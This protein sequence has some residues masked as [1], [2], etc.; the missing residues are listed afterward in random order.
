MYNQVRGCVKINAS[1]R[2]LYKF[3]NKIHCGHIY[4]FRQYVRKD[5]FYAEIYRHDLKKVT[6]FAGECGIELKHYE[7]E[8]ISKKLIRYRKRIGI[9]I[10]TAAVIAASVYFSNVVVTIDIQG[11]STVSDRDILAALDELDIRQGSFIGGIDFAY[12]EKELRLMIDDISWAAIRHTGNRIVVEVT[13]IVSKPDM[14]EERMPCNVI[15]DRAAQITYTSV[16]DGQ[17]MRIVG[18]Y[19][20]PGDMLISGIIEDSGGTVT[21][22]HAM[23]VIKG[24]YE[25]TVVFSQEYK[26]EIYQPTGNSAS[27]RYLKLFNLKI[28]LFIGKNEYRYYSEEKNE[29]KLSL[30]GREIP[31]SIVRENLTETKLSV[32]EYNDAELEELIMEKIYLYE[33]NFLADK[34]IMEREITSEKN[35]DALTYTVR[36]TLEGEIGEQREIFIK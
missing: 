5:V 34:E 1:G 12:C 24:I 2:N 9:A 11:N 26:R 7:C 16:Y 17:L 36:Y 18:D 35:G 27:E 6:E 31:I 4:C 22:H 13:E 33:K 10:G 19:V 21:K 25:E 14:V 32:K 30:F 29:R 8:T 28:P 3:I 15:A 20:M 23:G